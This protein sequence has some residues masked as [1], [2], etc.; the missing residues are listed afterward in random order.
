[1]E[2]NSERVIA[3]ID[4]FNLYFG[5]KAAS[6]RKYYWLDLRRMCERLLTENQKL[7]RVRY[8]TSRVS[9][10]PGK[11]R[12]Q[13]TYLEALATLPDFDVIEGQYV[14]DTKQCPGC[15]RLIFVHNE[16][17]TDVNIAVEITKDA[18]A[19]QFD[20]ALLVTGDS[21]QAPTVRMLRDLFLHKRLICA[22][23][24]RRTSNE[25][26]KLAAFI[27][28]NPGMLAACQLPS[29]VTKANG[30]VLRRP[31]EWQ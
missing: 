30:Y 3:Y 21:D 2:A 17:M 8:F 28:I 24:P 6:S 26:K 1:M 14:G 9:E 22:F 11:V 13:T 12:R 4:G 27:H 19:D 23:P 10:P 5:M 16:K 7:Q 15:G 18:H 25:L 20:T 31:V 29:E